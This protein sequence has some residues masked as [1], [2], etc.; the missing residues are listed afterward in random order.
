MPH[1]SRAPGPATRF[2]PRGDRVLATGRLVGGD[3]LVVST[4][5]VAVASDTETRWRREWHEVELGAWDDET[6]TVTITWVGGSPAVELACVE[7]VRRTLLEAF[8]ERV[9]ASVVHQE[10]AVLPGG[11]SA[12]AVIRRVGDGS[13]VSQVTADTAPSTPADTNAVERL[14]RRARR[15]VGL[16]D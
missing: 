9:D 15:A 2:S 1:R 7:P 10:Q 16:P 6:S 8:R 5:A 3:W 11:G 13:L 12:R 14:E 4:R